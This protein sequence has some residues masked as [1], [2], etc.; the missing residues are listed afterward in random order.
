MTAELTRPEPAAAPGPN[1]PRLLDALDDLIR[2]H[3]ALAAHDGGDDS[4]HA[5]LIAAEL[6]QQI[7]VI[8]RPAPRR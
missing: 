1:V 3:R 2:R 7:A 4:L 5:E 6:A 8:R